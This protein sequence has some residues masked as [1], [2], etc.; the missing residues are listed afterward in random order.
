MLDYILTAG[1]LPIA[2]CR[3]FAEINMSTAKWAECIGLIS[4]SKIMFSMCVLFL[5]RRTIF[6]IHKI[7]SVSAILLFLSGFSKWAYIAS[8]ISFVSLNTVSIEMIRLDNNFA[9]KLSRLALFKKVLA[10]ASTFVISY[11]CIK[12]ITYMLIVSMLII[13]LIPVAISN[14]DES[15]K[16]VALEVSKDSAYL[17]LIYFCMN[18]AHQATVWITVSQKS[19]MYVNISVF[20]SLYLSIFGTKFSVYP[21]LTLTAL[22]VGSMCV[23][24]WASVAMAVIAINTFANTYSKEFFKKRNPHSIGVVH[25]VANMGSELLLAILTF[26]ICK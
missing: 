14:N 19:L 11:F 17:G 26:S 24:K 1:C 9:K 3:Y 15:Q 2:I 13:G 16:S 10:F 5:S 20:T 18:V 7:V 12:F 8:I 25:T 22:I 23:N 21:A 6:N 4:I